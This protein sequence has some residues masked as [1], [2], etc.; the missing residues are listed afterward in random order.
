MPVRISSKEHN[1][2]QNR[3]HAGFCKPTYKFIFFSIDKQTN[4]AAQ[5]GVRMAMSQE[6]QLLTQF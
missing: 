4:G 5:R 1:F 3:K 6:V 2:F